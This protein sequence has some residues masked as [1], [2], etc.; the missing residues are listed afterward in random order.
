MSSDNHHTIQ[1]IQSLLDEGYK[2]RTSNIT[3]SVLL[4]ERARDLSEEINEPNLLAKSL[5]KLSLYHMIHGEFGKSMEL[6]HKAIHY[7]ETVD[8]KLNL[9][10]AKFN[11][12]SV[13]YKTDNYHLGLINLLDCL[14]IYRQANDHHN[15]G[16][17]YKAIGTI[18]EYFGDHTKATAAYQ[19]TIEHAQ[20]AGDKSLESNAYNPLS[21]IYLKKGD[22]DKAFELAQSS[23]NIKNET[24]DIRG[25][26]FAIYAKAKVLTAWGKFEEAEKNYLES[27]RIHYSFNEL[28]GTA[29]S[30]RKL[31]EMYLLGGQLDKALDTLT[32]AR[33]F[34]YQNHIAIIKYK[35][36]YHI[37]QLYKKLGKPEKALGFLEE[38]FMQKDLVV[39]N[40]T[41]TIIDNF[42]LLNKV[43]SMRRE[44][45]IQKE[46]AEI[47][48]KK[49]RAE[50]LA[51]MKQDFL[52]TMSHEIRTPLN[53]VI[54]ISN[55]L[56]N[57]NSNP[58]EKDL[59]NS[60]K[61]ASNNLLLLINDILD[62]TK[63][64]SGKMT[65]DKSPTLLVNVL[66]NIKATY[67]GMAVEKGLKLYLNHDL[68][69]T[70]YYE[71][72]DNRISQI[73]VNLLGNAIKYTE[74]GI[75]TIEVQT[76]NKSA[77]SDL[78]R[79]SISDTGVGIPTE[80]QNEIFESFSQTQKVLT[81]K[82]GGSGLGLA[83]V[84]KL[85]ELHQSEINL[86]SSPN[87]GSTFYFDLFLTKVEKESLIINAP[88]NTLEG[89]KVLL[90]EDNPI[91]A[92]VAGKLLSKWGIKSNHQV[93]GLKGIEL[94]AQ[95]KF[96]LILM[97]I[98]MPEMDGFEAS[99][100]IRTH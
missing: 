97:D 46:R 25:L 43:E 57:N 22:L 61:F 54:T 9:A 42:E 56:G 17:V 78:I 93:N 60:L 14:Q 62:F 15:I 32:K 31:G 73:L 37:Y 18:Y 87:M 89:K 67:E 63:L 45:E 26:A 76:I 64:E 6:A 4:T 71:I 41:L 2:K 11:L 94:A 92:L 65:L 3:E 23:I 98:H 33:D 90:V 5:S 86:I 82:Q 12:A 7:F 75:I 100:W 83:I 35:S 96:D 29:M 88:Q 51:N 10:D 80:I 28:L 34:S 95:E 44:S 8:D 81:K 19:S 79:F 58:E 70:I 99:I 59:I 1:K 74:K 38:Y 16:R 13:F 21:G 72:D 69:E 20:L 53:A 39:K 91:N 36:N 24:G 27:L 77:Q 85:I 47:L 30:Y 50:T 84:K 52:S 55:L 40:Q 49:K 48:E 66:Q 68:D